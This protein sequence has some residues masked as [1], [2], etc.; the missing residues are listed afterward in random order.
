MKHFRGLALV[1]TLCAVAACNQ[2]GSGTPDPNG[3]GSPSNVG[4]L[5]PAILKGRVTT[6]QGAPLAGV[7]V[8]ADNT[9]LY[10]S[11]LL[12]ATDAN[13]Y[14][15]I[16]LSSF[17]TTWHAGASLDTTF[18]GENYEISL[19][20]DDDSDFATAT[21]AIRNFTWK[22]SGEQ[23]EGDSY[24]GSLVYVYGDFSTS[25]FLVDDVELTLTPEGPLIDGSTGQAIVQKPVGGE[26]N[27]VPI[28]RYTV[29]GRYLEPGGAARPLLI[30]PDGTDNFQPAQ[31]LTFSND[32]YY[33]TMMEMI[34]RPQ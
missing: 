2:V 13:G 20:P 32:S 16:D 18:E 11:N 8:F 17:N 7:E 5:E 30:A 23:P 14:Y 9:L 4:G 19:A 1:L 27:D 31:S 26:I 22:L 28:G 15:R 21:G 10:D 24:Y 33:G 34:V 25:D 6:S 12:A 3:P 29:T